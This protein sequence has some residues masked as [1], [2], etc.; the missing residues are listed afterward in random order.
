VAIQGSVSP[1]QLM[2]NDGGH[3][4]GHFNFYVR[5]GTVSTWQSTTPS[6]TYNTIMKNNKQ[7]ISDDKGPAKP[8][9]V[10]DGKTGSLC[11]WERELVDRH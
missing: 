9:A 6:P 5:S 8:L 10:R 3:C 7:S 2:V 1:L 4:A 11:T